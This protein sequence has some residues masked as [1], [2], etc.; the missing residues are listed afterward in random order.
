MTLIWTKPTGT[1]ISFK[2][3]KWPAAQMFVIADVYAA[4]TLHC[5]LALHQSLVLYE[6]QFTKRLYTWFLYSN[7]NDLMTEHRTMLYMVHSQY[8]NT[9]QYV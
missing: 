8:T 6:F 9:M 5:F 7:G 2:G 4:V 1:G 3:L